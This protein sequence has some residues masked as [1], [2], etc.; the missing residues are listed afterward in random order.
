ME[1]LGRTCPLRHRQVV[2]G[3]LEH[4]D[5]LT[6]DEGG[7]NVLGRQVHDEEPTETLL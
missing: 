3:G 1:G 6:L 7:R 5:H 4:R 2:V